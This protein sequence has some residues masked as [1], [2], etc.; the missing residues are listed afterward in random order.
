MCPVVDV[1]KM[2]QVVLT[3]LTLQQSMQLQM[4]ADNAH[5]T[6]MLC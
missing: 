6:V 2:L 3:C 5:L 4:S 1:V